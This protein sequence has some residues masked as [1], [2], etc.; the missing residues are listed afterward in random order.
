MLSQ[1][2]NFLEKGDYYYKN[3]IEPNCYNNERFLENKE[4]IM[5]L[6]S[7]IEKRIAVW[8]MNNMET[9]NIEEKNRE[10]NMIFFE[11]L[12]IDPISEI[13]KIENEYNIKIDKSKIKQKSASTSQI[14]F[15]REKVLTSWLTDMSENEKNKI[16]N[17]FNHYN[18]KIYDAYTATP[19]L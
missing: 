1:K 17:I 9:L 10:W 2:I 11:N 5:S 19:I 16:Q 15:K 7:H 18:L 12:F 14:R 6:N 3:Y 13:E 8:C 4:Y